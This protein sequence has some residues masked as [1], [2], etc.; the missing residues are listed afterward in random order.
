MP[1]EASKGARLIL[2][3]CPPM[4]GTRSELRSQNNNQILMTEKELLKIAGQY[5][6]LH[7][8][9]T[10]ARDARQAFQKKHLDGKT[11]W[12][13]CSWGDTGM[14]VDISLVRYLSMYPDETPKLHE[15]EDDG[16]RKAYMKYPTHFVGE[17]R[18]G[19]SL[20]VEAHTN[21]TVVGDVPVKLTQ[22]E[23]QT[24][25]YRGEV[26]ATDADGVETMRMQG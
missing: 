11:F 23:I 9:E 10:R 7:R 16:K 17:M 25:I 18:P 13:S 24:R 1:A 3:L 22:E 4:A 21:M 6:K 15:F 19:Y 2:S 8:M 12:G 14:V 5:D 20:W 26:E